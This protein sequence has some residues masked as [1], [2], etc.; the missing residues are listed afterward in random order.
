M[1]LGVYPPK[2]ENGIRTYLKDAVHEYLKE[3]QKT[4]YQENIYEAGLQIYTTIDSNMQVIAEANVLKM[5]PK[6]QM[7]FEK[8]SIGK[9]KRKV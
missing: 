6:I 1:P 4:H 3:W 5:M 8:N 7:D 2:P 9:K